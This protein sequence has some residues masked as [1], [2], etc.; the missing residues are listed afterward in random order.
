GHRTKCFRKASI[1]AQSLKEAKDD[2]YWIE[3]ILFA[4][5]LLLT[6]SKQDRSIGHRT[7]SNMSETNMRKLKF[8]YWS[9]ELFRSEEVCEKSHVYAF[10]AFL[11]HLITERAPLNNFDYPQLLY[12]VGSGKLVVE[13]PGDCD[14]LIASLIAECCRFNPEKRPSFQDTKINTKLTSGSAMLFIMSCS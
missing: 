7:V 12:N 6:V 10:G 9:P 8:G 11:I 4:R 14:P 3:F 5:D 1:P 13:P 2:N